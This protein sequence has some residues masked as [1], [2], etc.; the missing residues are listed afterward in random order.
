MEKSP[1]AR[2]VQRSESAI[3]AILQEQQARNMPIKE[4]CGIYEIHEATFYNW[5]KRYGAVPDKAGS[6]FIEMEIGQRSSDP[7]LFAEVELRGK[8]VIRLFHPVEPSYFK[9][10]L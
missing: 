7:S 9:A 6:G 4:L 10:L 5:R 1:G 8:L 3:R 2:R